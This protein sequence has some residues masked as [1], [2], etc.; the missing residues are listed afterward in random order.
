LKHLKSKKDEI[1]EI[2]DEVD[3]SVIQGQIHEP[4]WNALT[5]KYEAQLTDIEQDLR[6]IK[7]RI[8]RRKRSTSK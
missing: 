6:K 8:A 5:A 7:E 1:V 3:Q 2:L 4:T